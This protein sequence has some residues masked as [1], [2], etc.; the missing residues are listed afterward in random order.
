M[1][2]SRIAV[3]LLGPVPIV[4]ASLAVTQWWRTSGPAI[5][6]G[7]HV[8]HAE[9]PRSPPQPPTASSDLARELADGLAKACEAKAKA[10]RAKLGED[11]RVI[12]GSPFVVA[13]NLD[14]AG[15]ETWLRQTIAPAARALDHAYFDRADGTCFH[16]LVRRRTFV[17]PL[18]QGPLR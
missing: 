6:N 13:G 1:E 9:E 15:L 2:R 14:E 3:F 4:A 10:W 16:T 17:R 18:C 11:C 5:V 12:V 8:L 7:N